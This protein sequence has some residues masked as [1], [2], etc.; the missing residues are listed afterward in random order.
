MFPYSF[1]YVFYEQ[2]LT[3]WVD[4]G[5]ALGCALAAVFVVVVVFTGADLFSAAVMLLIVLLTL[6]NISGS[7][8]W[9]GISLNAISLV[10]LVMS[11]GISIEFS[12]HLVAAFSTAAQEEEEEEELNRNSRAV[13]K[14][15]GATA[16]NGVAEHGNA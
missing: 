1:F 12:A 5:T 15:N 13:A 6:V 16:E 7:M 4:A 14:A 3:I 10:N 2:Y 8:Y 9:L 11:V